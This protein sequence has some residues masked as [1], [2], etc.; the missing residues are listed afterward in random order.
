MKH[1]SLILGAVLLLVVLVS[2]VALA[3]G[4]AGYDLPW[5]TTDSGGGTSSGAGY[6]LRGAIG[7]PDAGPLLTGAGYQL[8]GGFW[9]G[10][11]ANEPSPYAIFLP[12]TIR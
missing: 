7:Q 9:G 6:S 1:K 12:L 11:L 3:A 8:N 10:V 2:G 5:W 4:E